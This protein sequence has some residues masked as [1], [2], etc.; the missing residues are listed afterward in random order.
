MRTNIWL[1]YSRDTILDGIPF[2][3]KIKPAK[4]QEERGPPGVISREAGADPEMEKSGPGTKSLTVSVTLI[5][6]SQKYRIRRG[7]R[8]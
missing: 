7:I 8:T 2:L 3:S 1:G 5:K 4:K 6:I